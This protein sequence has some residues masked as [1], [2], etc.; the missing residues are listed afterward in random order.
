MNN[1]AK[2][3]TSDSGTVTAKQHERIKDFLYLY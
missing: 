1:L 3:I 2:D